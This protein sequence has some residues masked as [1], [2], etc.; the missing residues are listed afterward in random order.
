MIQSNAKLV[1]DLNGE[2]LGKYEVFIP[3]FSQD[4]G[5]LILNL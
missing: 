1:E 4:R 3:N 2:S 5:I